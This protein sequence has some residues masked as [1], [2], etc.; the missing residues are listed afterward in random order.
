MLHLLNMVVY[1][2]RRLKELIVSETVS[3][4]NRWT[5]TATL[6]RDRPDFLSLS[7][8]INRLILLFKPPHCLR[9]V[10][11]IFLTQTHLNYLFCCTAAAA[12]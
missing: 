2:D 12:G 5:S 8:M 7:P 3:R 9:P 11:S 10:C 6:S 1:F 4:G